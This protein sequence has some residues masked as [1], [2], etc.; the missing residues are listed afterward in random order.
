MR[1][2]R[3]AALAYYY[4][5]ERGRPLDS[6]EIDWYRAIQTLRCDEEPVDLPLSSVCAGPDTDTGLAAR[7]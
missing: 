2:V 1:E 6:P 3:I 4:W 7:R 5:E